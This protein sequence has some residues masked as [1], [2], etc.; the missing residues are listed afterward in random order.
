MGLWNTVTGWL[1]FGGS[2]TPAPTNTADT[3][4][5]ADAYALTAQ[6]DRF[7]AWTAAGG[8]ILNYNTPLVTPSNP[9]VYP[10][11][12]TVGASGS[13]DRAGLVSTKSAGGS[14]TL[15]SGASGIPAVASAG[16]LGG[17]DIN[18]LLTFGAVGLIAWKMLGS[19]DKGG[20]RR[21]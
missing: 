12:S 9:Q 2:V 8:T 18:T 13:L 14:P 10:T 6:S 5:A 21:K 17:M 11:P 15:Y 3:K 19:K 7:D 4:A 16:I 20:R 1:G